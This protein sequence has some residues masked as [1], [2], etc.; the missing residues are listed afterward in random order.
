[1]SSARLAFGILRGSTAC[2]PAPNVRV[3]AQ[4]VACSTDTPGHVFAPNCLTR[5]PG[6]SIWGCGVDFALDTVMTTAV[7]PATQPTT[8]PLVSL[9]R[10]AISR[11]RVRVLALAVVTSLAFGYRAVA[12]STYG[13][14]EDEVNK[15]RAIEQYGQGHFGTNAEHPM[16]MKLAMW[17][18]VELAGV[19]N[20]MAPAG[21]TVAIESAIR[22]P[23][24]LAG[25]LATL[26]LFGLAELLF[27]TSVAI[28]ASLLWALDVNAIA[29]NRI[30]KEDTLLLF[31]FLLAMWCYERAK[32]QGAADPIGAQRWY[33]RSGASFGLMLASKYMP[34]YLGIYAFFNVI[35]DR[36]PGA[37]RP[38][39][40]RYYGA[41]L[42]TF[43][44]ANA[45]V[46]MPETWQYCVRYVQ[47][48]TLVHH[49]YLYAGHLYV[50]NIPISPLGVPATFYFRLLAT[51]VPLAV[52][53]AT[54][55]GLIELVRRRHERGF[56]LLR[57]WLV[58]VLVP[59]SLMAAKF[60][61]YAL[62]LFAA[63]DLVAAVGLVAGIGW[64]LRKRWLSRAT[65]VTV[66]LLAGVVSIV[67]L[68]FGLQSASPFYSVFR[69]A[70]GERIAAAGATFPE[71]AYDY[72][73][74]EAVAAI[75]ANAEPAAFVVSDAPAVVAYYLT[76]AGRTDLHVQ[77]L[78][79]QGIPYV[80]QPSWVI[81]QDDHATFENHDVVE[82]LRRQSE[83]WREFRAGDA[84]TAQVFRLTGR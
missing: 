16:L 39:K 43:V 33:G 79:G 63:V 78:S 64:L 59:Y 22:F 11:A 48:T 57:V 19:W 21:R 73:V 23:N 15:V 44:A 77:S 40:V 29:I 4:R 37:N 70:V 24:V 9:E 10:F 6:Q 47:G 75:A 17:G 83:P 1:M 54:A 68:A 71:E 55:A 62:P 58:F 41:M 32:R 13:L 65:R 36:D 34:Q 27:G 5:A 45:A 46:L 8:W 69:N 51:K 76:A 52:L 31:F 67:A 72:G 66:S 80:R 49:G 74:R 2:V 60:M 35:S 38:D 12:L 84:L 18:S 14:S 61:R 56:I 3:S 28:V 81:V 30:G 82:Q 53:G 42:L 25:T 20:H 50:T 7:F 26:V